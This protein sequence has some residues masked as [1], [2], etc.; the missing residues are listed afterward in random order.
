MGSL[1]HDTCCCIALCSACLS[2]TGALLVGSTQGAACC[3]GLRAC[4][5]AR[6][7]GRAAGTVI[8]HGMMAAGR[9]E[10][11]LLLHQDQQ[12]QLTA[13]KGPAATKHGLCCVVHLSSNTTPCLLKSLCIMSHRCGCGAYST[14]RTL[15]CL[16]STPRMH[17]RRCHVH[18]PSLC[19][20]VWMHASNNT[21]QHLQQQ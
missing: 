1:T 12:R 20:L 15:L 9:L 19:V 3:F 2:G 11:F 13:D 10:Q 14:P 7:R 18:A 16:T 6:R 21:I 5:A 4:A 8:R 17:A